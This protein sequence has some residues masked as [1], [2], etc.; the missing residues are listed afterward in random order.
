VLVTSVV[1]SD[2]DAKVVAE[3]DMTEV[4]TVG[5]ANEALL[6]AEESL[7]ITDDASESTAEETAEENVAD[8]IAETMPTL[9]SNDSLFI[10]HALLVGV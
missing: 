6:V 3:G 8:P 10:F 9:T 1:L 7:L 4:N 5:V 2:A